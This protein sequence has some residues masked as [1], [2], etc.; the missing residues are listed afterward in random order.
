MQMKGGVDINDDAGLEKEADVMGAKLRTESIQKKSPVATKSK[1]PELSQIIAFL[2]LTT[3]LAG[4]SVVS[5]KSMCVEVPSAAPVRLI[6]FSI[7]EFAVTILVSAE[8]PSK[9]STAEVLPLPSEVHS[10]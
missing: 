9:I 7:V 8:A 10:P 5:V 6:T 1:F 3:V 2:K 4:K